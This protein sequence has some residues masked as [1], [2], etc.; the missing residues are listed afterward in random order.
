MTKMNSGVSMKGVALSLTSNYEITVGNVENLS[1]GVTIYA[2]EEG[3]SPMS[4][5]TEYVDFI[6]SQYAL[7]GSFDVKPYNAPWNGFNPNR[8]ATSNLEHTYLFGPSISPCAYTF[9]DLYRDFGLSESAAASYIEVGVDEMSIP[10]GPTVM[11]V[12]VENYPVPGTGY[13]EFYQLYYLN[14]GS[15]VMYLDGALQESSPAGTYPVY[16]AGD[17]VG[18]VAYRDIDGS[19]IINWFLNGIW[20]FSYNP[21][22]VFR[23]SQVKVNFNAATLGYTWGH[24]PIVP[25]PPVPV[26]AKIT[27]E[28]SP[29]LYESTYVNWF[30]SREVS[31]T[32][33]II[34]T[35]FQTG[36]DATYSNSDRTLQYPAGIPSFPHVGLNS[37]ESGSAGNG[38]IYEITQ[39]IG[40]LASDNTQLGRVGFEESSYF[41]ANYGGGYGNYNS[42]D[43][44]GVVIW[45]SDDGTTTTATWFVNGNRATDTDMSGLTSFQLYVEFEAYIV[46]PIIS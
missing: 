17:R 11:G 22:S 42:P 21:V 43:T 28:S 26:A 39:D 5:E 29:L 9:Y 25:P 36:S 19:S 2:T 23:F 7:S 38:F 46:R 8:L 15:S 32:Y 13:Q 3:V 40:S 14:D 24:T 6:D 31:G 33:T 34:D 1:S 16:G 10:L 37:T 27:I 45:V 44:I 41:S 20:Q 18:M 12:G 30:E 35:P 4:Y